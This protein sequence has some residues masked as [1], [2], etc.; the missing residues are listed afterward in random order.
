MAKKVFSLEVFFEPLQD[1]L[2]YFSKR[3]FGGLAIYYLDLMCFCLMESPGDREYRGENFDYDIWNGVMVCTDFVHHD[4]LIKDF[5]GFENHP[6]LKKWL[7]LPQ[8]HE[9]FEST[10]ESV[11]ESTLKGD[12]RIGIV[13]SKKKRKNKSD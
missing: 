8:S 7:Y 4:S 2:S 12:E 13:P 10:I 5:P 6:V 11:V 1:D 9:D 3:M